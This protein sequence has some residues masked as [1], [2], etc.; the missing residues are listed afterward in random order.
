MIIGIVQKGKFQLHLNFVKINIW[1]KKLFIEYA[2]LLA[3]K[4][5]EDFPHYLMNT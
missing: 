3:L 1:T 2:M 5:P 4:Y